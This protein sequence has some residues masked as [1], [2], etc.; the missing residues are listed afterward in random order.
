MRNKQREEAIERALVLYHLPVEKV[1]TSSQV[2]E[3]NRKTHLYSR[4]P[5]FN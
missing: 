4:L 3:I 1:L 2:K 5:Y